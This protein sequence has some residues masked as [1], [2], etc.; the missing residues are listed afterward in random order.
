MAEDKTTLVD[1]QAQ[2]EGKLTGKDATIHGRVRGEIALTGKLLIGEDGKV[3]ASVSAESVE[4]AGLLEGDVRARAVTLRE[5]ARV[6]GRV[7]AQA[8]VVREGAFLTGPVASGE[9][10]SKQA[11]APAPASAVHPIPPKPPESPGA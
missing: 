5:S 7:E 4:V 1:A 8:L 3:H 6:K 9:A 10:P 2:I 11:P